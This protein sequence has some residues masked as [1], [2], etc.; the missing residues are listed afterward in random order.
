[1]VEHFNLPENKHTGVEVTI[2]E[3]MNWLDPI[4]ARNG[5]H[6]TSNNLHLPTYH[7]GLHKQE[8]IVNFFY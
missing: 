5:E 1:M 8:K 3:Q 2:I 4:Y 6:C 7:E